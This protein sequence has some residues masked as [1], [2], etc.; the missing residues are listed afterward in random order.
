MERSE[1][2]KKAASAPQRRAKAAKA[3]DSPAPSEGVS[4]AP[5]GYDR[6]FPREVTPKT[7]KKG[8]FFWAV[9]LEFADGTALTASTWSKHVAERLLASLGQRT[10]V[11]L[12]Q[13]EH[14]GVVYY[15]I[16]EVI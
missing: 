13:K 15:N 8:R 14:D 11:A 10:D 5:A 3:P 9:K 7:S 16:A 2:S 1:P 6:V 12:T 4:G